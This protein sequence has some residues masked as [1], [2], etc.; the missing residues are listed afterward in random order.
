MKSRIAY[1]AQ[2]CGGVKELANVT[3]S[4]GRRSAEN[5]HVSELDLKEHLAHW[6]GKTR[7]YSAARKIIEDQ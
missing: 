7:T 6:P 1:S 4:N 3:P 2:A 5:P